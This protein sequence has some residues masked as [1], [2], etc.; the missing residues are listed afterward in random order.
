MSRLAQTPRDDAD[1]TI[2]QDVLKLPDGHTITYHALGNAEL[3]LILFVVGSS[4]L[5]W[6]YRRLSI[7]MSGIFRCVYYDKRGFLPTD[8]DKASIAEK[9]NELV[10]ATQVADDAAAL[11]KHISPRTPIHVFGTSTGGTAVLDLAVRYPELIRT[12]VLHEPITFSVMPPTELKDE[13]LT[14]YRS[15][16]LFEDQVEGSKTYGSYMFHPHSK[17]TSSGLRSSLSRQGQNGVGTRKR[18]ALPPKSAEEFNSRQGT[19]EGAAML[20]YEVDVQGVRSVRDKLLLI[21]GNESKDWP[22]SQPVVSLA[23]TLGDGVKVSELAGDHLSFAARRRLVT[24]AK[25]LVD[26][27]REASRVSVSTDS[28]PKSRL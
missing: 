6:L 19:Q 16:P 9:T 22:I 8:T 23:Q 24:F 21:R 14:L 7:E 17:E 13:I 10:L 20:A 27:L 18:Y 11:I 12:A 26:L 15:L 5:G 1:A 2:S 25:Q 4:G 28:E 3:P